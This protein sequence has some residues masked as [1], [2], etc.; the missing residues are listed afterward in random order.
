[1]RQL[2]ILIPQKNR[3]CFEYLQ[4][5]DRKGCFIDKEGFIPDQNSDLGKFGF[6]RVCS[7]IRRQKSTLGRLR[8]IVTEK[9]V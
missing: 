1:M 6:Y 2:T 4:L 5:I 8:L 7:K 3:E 9:F